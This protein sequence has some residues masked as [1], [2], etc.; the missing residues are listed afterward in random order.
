ME[1]MSGVFR[2]MVGGGRKVN[3]WMKCFVLFS[4]FRHQTYDELSYV[5]TGMKWLKDTTAGGSIG[6]RGGSRVRTLPPV[7][8]TR[9]PVVAFAGVVVV[10]EAAPPAAVAPVAPVAGAAGAVGS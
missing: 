10:F 7:G 6:C 4:S 3:I 2:S 5:L 1:G 8:P 9:G